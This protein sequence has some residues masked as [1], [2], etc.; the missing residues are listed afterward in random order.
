MTAEPAMELRGVTINDLLLAMIY[1]MV[2]AML[3][4][5]DNTYKHYKELWRPLLGGA[6]IALL[7]IAAFDFAR[8]L[9]T[10]TWSGFNL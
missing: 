8:Y 10:G 3:S 1:A 9:L 2:W 7:Q 4:K 5:K 6:L